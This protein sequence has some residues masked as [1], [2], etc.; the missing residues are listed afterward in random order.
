MLQHAADVRSV[1]ER[2][3]MRT[4]RKS[5]GLAPAKWFPPPEVPKDY[6]P[7]HYFTSTLY[8][9]GR[10]AIMHGLLDSSCG[11]K[12][13]TTLD[14]AMPT[15]NADKRGEILGETPLSSPHMPRKEHIGSVFDLISPEDK[16]RLSALQTRFE[17][18]V[19]YVHTKIS[20][21]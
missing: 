19:R 2:E 20:I 21:A 3:A 7:F 12:L 5:H 8:S 15:M 16:Q 4:F 11:P 17:K 6:H 10:C 13:C 14:T 9:D 1:N 18:S